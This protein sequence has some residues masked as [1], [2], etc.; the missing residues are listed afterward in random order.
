MADEATAVSLSSLQK[1]VADAVAALKD[2]EKFDVV[3]PAPVPEVVSAL[4]SVL[5]L[6][7]EILAKL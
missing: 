1:I 6:A 3:L 7:S 2:V 5:N 4:E